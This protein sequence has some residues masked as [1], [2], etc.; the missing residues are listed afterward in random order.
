MEITTAQ[1]ASLATFI[2]SRISS[3]DRSWLGHSVA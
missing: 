3:H 1:L 2:M